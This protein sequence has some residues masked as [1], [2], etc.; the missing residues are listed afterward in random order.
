M[1]SNFIILQASE[2]IGRP[3]GI[4]IAMVFLIWLAFKK[5]DRDS[6]DQNKMK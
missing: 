6:N 4:I 2:T 3:I 1:L 5:K